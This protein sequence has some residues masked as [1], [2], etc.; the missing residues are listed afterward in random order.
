MAQFTRRP[1]GDHRRRPVHHPLRAAF[2]KKDGSLAAPVDELDG[3]ALPISR[4]RI[5]DPGV[6]Y[7]TTSS[8]YI[9]H[10]FTGRFS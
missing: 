8:G 2:L 1:A 9:T 10:R 6:A 3:R 5:D 7:V 4:S